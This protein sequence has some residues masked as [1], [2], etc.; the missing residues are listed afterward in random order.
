MREAIRN[1]GLDVNIDV[2]RDGE[3]ALEYLDAVCGTEDSPCP[4]LILL[5]LNLPKR[6]GDEVLRHIRANGR[7]RSAK[8]LIVSSSDAPRDRIAVEALAI[9]GYFHKPSS[10]EEFMGMGALVKTLLG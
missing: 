5:D 10:Y 1:S 2:V 3:A 8:V 4:D 7:C 6:S 9:A